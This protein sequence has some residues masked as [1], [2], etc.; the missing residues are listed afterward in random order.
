MPSPGGAGDKLPPQG[1]SYGPTYPG[2]AAENVFDGNT[3]TQWASGAYQAQQ[4]FFQFNYGLNTYDFSQ[5][6]LKTGALPA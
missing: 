2:T 5:V 1:V 4:A 6:R 3:N